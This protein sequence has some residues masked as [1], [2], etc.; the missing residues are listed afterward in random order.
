VSAAP[1]RRLGPAD[2]ARVEQFTRMAYKLAWGF[3]RQQA[4]DVPVDELI[5]EALF[6]LAYAAGR[7]DEARGVPFRA[8]AVM[9]MRHRLTNGVRAWR[10]MRRVPPVSALP[11]RDDDWWETL[12]DRRAAPEPGAAAT[13]RDLCE[14]MRRGLPARWYTALRLFHAEGQTLQQIGRRMGIT[15]ERVRQLVLKAERKARGLLRDQMAS[16]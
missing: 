15:R 6:G 14:R 7:Y 10:R 3:A 1:V 2:H 13:A 11:A 8:Y 12:E 9:V 16:Q 4:R 5:A